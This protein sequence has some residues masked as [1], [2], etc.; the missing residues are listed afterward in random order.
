MDYCFT[1]CLFWCSHLS[2]SIIR[3]PTMQHK[4]PN[5]F[6]YS[7]ILSPKSR[8]WL[9]PLSSVKWRASLGVSSLLLRR[10]GVTL[11]YWDSCS[12]AAW[13]VMRPGTDKGAQLK[14]SSTPLRHG[15]ME[16]RPPPP[17]PPQPKSVAINCPCH[18]V[19][20]SQS[21]VCTLLSCPRW[22]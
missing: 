14:L 13:C 19:F 9:E 8:L 16:V 1:L 2:C 18:K 15:G 5:L 3:R 20:V 6:L 4:Q 11:G 12:P 10:K 21:Q 7:S 17:A 22:Q